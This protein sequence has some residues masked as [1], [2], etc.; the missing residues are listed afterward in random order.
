MLKKFEEV[1]RRWRRSNGVM[2]GSPLWEKKKKKKKKKRKE[3]KRNGKK[4]KKKK[5]RNSWKFL[6]IE[7]K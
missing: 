4:K 2:A 7:E 1:W 5:K 6:E 3:K